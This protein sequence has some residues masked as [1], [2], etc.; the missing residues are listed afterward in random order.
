GA[1]A[2]DAAGRAQPARVRLRPA[3]PRQGLPQPHRVPLLRP[4]EL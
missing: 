2:A 1:R 4:G 3:R